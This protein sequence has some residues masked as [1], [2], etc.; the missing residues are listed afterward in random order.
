MKNSITLLTILL[1]I[2]LNSYGQ[3]Q[4][5]L[6]FN[7]TNA[8]VNTN[9]VL[10]Y[11]TINHTAGYEVPKSS[12]IQAFYSSSFWFGGEDVNNQ[13][14]LAAQKYHTD[15]DFSTGPLSTFGGGVNNGVPY[16][17]AEIDSA[18]MAMYNKII[19]LDKSTVQD[20]ITW[21]NCNNGVTPQN[22]CN[23]VVAPSSNDMQQILNWPAHGDVALGQDYYLA[24]FYDNPNGPNGANGVYDPI[25]D[26][27]YPCIPGHRV[28]YIIFNDKGAA[29]SSGGEPIGLEFHMMVY[30]YA[31]NDFLDNTTFVNLKVINRSTQTLYNFKVAN[32]SDPMIGDNSD[33]YVGSNPSK[34][35]IY[36]YNSDNNDAEYGVNPPAVGVVLLNAPISV[37]GVI[38]NQSGIPAMQ[39]P[40]ISAEYWGY[41]NGQ[42]GN[43]GVHF[44][45]GGNGYNGTVPTNFMYDD[46]NNWSEVTEGNAAGD[47]QMFIAT[48]QGTFSPG[49]VKAYDFAFIYARKGNNL[50]NVDSLFVIAD[51]VQSFYDNQ[52]SNCPHI[53]DPTLGT[54]D[55]EDQINNINLYPNP[56]QGQFKID[57]QG[58]FDLE[59]YSIAGQLIYQKNNVQPHQNISAPNN[60][61]I[62]FV[63]VHQNGQIATVK[64]II[65]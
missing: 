30:Q 22:Q 7:Q 47:R 17:D 52:A 4:I 51:S 33:D 25:A 24:P 38:N 28:A 60:K 64:M 2:S 54:V 12:G 21:W 3:A 26:G 19:I 39:S 58:A 29:H 32:F 44:T 37:A 1:L 9:G 16:G 55:I 59:I 8:I 61:G 40:E 53:F 14:R 15:A 13:I 11:D 42:W 20:F 10:F 62:Y 27:D 41:M 48:D 6:D 45:Q 43:S 49:A 5:N 23:N 46:I 18:T 65:E 50:Q 36:A 56:A 63:K 35:M 57:I 31:T 34:N